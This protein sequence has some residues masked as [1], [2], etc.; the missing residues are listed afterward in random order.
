MIFFVKIKL[1]SK[2]SPK[3]SL[4]TS[5]LNGGQQNV[6]IP[7][8]DLDVFRNAPDFYLGANLPQAGLSSATLRSSRTANTQIRPSLAGTGTGSGSGA[9]A[10]ATP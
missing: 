1:M 3:H 2:E 6:F 7:Q 4:W 9:Q 10:T 5:P 8:T